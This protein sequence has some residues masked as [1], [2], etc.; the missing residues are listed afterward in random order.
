M[1]QFG[2][3][4]KTQIKSLNAID[5]IFFKRLRL[6]NFLIEEG[7]ERNKKEIKSIDLQISECIKQRARMRRSIVYKKDLKAGNK[8]SLDDLDTKRPG[9]GFPPQMIDELV[10]K[11]LA[12]DVKRDILLNENDILNK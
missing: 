12:N 4:Y 3:K 6:R 9:T 10:G 1:N 11:T 8:L 5:K 7:K 2:P